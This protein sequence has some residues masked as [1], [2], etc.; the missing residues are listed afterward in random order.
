[1]STIYVPLIRN[2][3]CRLVDGGNC[4]INL[5]GGH[6]D[7]ANLPICTLFDH[8]SWYDD[9]GTIGGEH[10]LSSYL[11]L[12]DKVEFRSNQWRQSTRQASARRLEF[13]RQPVIVS[14]Q[15]AAPLGLSISAVN[16][17][18]LLVRIVLCGRVGVHTK[19][20]P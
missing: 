19:E 2:A 11:W 10:Q 3:R 7:N 6:R 17:S 16:A 8:P 18:T 1:M 14:R 4:T 12:G 15:H 20:V 5:L 13:E 9:S